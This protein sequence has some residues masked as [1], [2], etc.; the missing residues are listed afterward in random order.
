MSDKFYEVKHKGKCAGFFRT[1]KAANKYA[2]QFKKNIE[3]QDYN[4]EVAERHFLD[5]TLE[6]ED[7]EFNWGAWK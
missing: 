2:L 1:K 5:N 6:E 4:V 3:G 7:G